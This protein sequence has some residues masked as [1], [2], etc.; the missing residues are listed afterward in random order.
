MAVAQS[1][2]LKLFPSGFVTHMTQS[3]PS[4]EVNGGAIKYPFVCAKDRAPHIKNMSHPVQ[5]QFTGPAEA[6]VSAMS[7]ANF[8]GED[9]KQWH[10][11]KVQQF[12]A[13]NAASLPGV[14]KGRVRKPAHAGGTDPN[15]PEHIT[16]TFKAGN[17]EIHSSGPHGGAW[18]VY[19]G[20]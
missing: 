9:P 1:G 12:A 3:S 15:E 14:T 4:N 5:V 11:D 19:T 2:A 8:G 16:V 10:V 6:E 17:R 13:A 18:H 20:R 7:A